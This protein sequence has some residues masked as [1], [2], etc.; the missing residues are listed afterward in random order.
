LGKNCKNCK[1]FGACGRKSKDFGTL[2]QKVKRAKNSKKQHIYPST[3]VPWML[4]TLKHTIFAIIFQWELLFGTNRTNKKNPKKSLTKSQL[5]VKLCGTPCMSPLVRDQQI[6]VST[7][8]QGLTNS[9]T[10]TLEQK[11]SCASEA[12]VWTSQGTR[13]GC[14][15]LQGRNVDGK[16][17][18]RINDPEEKKATH[19]L[20]IPFRG[21]SCNV[22]C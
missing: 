20:P 7:A 1:D 18:G 19:S 10:P 21:T 12:A 16:E 17:G 14:G 15:S 8:L 2:D 5:N 11:P 9:A 13:G 6:G 3:D 4:K 22:P